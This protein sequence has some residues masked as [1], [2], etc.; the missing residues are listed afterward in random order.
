LSIFA[1]QQ[2]FTKEQSIM[3]VKSPKELF[4]AMLTALRNSTERSST[5]YTELSELA[6]NPEIQEAL[7]ARAYIS[8]QDVAKLDEAF[9]LVGE[10]PVN[11]VEHVQETLMEDF[12]KQLAEVQSVEARRLLILAKASQVSHL[13]TAAYTALVAAADITGNYGVGVLLE[14]CLADNLAFAERTR[15]LVR[16]VIEARVAAAAA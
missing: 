12:R 13:R 8:R 16:K 14:S 9:K 11:W 4:V 10:K 2:K 15:H 5:I 3:P 6:Q 7:A 1:P